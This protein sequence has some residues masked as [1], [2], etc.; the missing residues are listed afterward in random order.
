MIIVARE[1]QQDL[2]TALS[3]HHITNQKRKTSAHL[4]PN[5]RYEE[6][7][8]TIGRTPFHQRVTQTPATFALGAI[9]RR[10]SSTIAAT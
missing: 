1:L 3:N 10:R 5:R 6:H 8:D 4:L 2:I 9:E 7:F